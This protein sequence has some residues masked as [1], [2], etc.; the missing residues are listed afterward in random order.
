MSVKFVD[1]SD[2]PRTIE[3]LKEALSAV[4]KEF[5]TASFSPVML[6]YVVIMDALRELI[7]IREK[8]EKGD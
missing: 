5:I 7:Y 3:E 6:H 8:I 1:D 4:Q 2:K